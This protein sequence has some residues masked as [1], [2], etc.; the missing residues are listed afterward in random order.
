MN[1][2]S[3]IQRF[4]DWLKKDVELSVL[5]PHKG[6]VKE[7]DMKPIRIVGVV[8]A[9][10]DQKHRT[11]QKLGPGSLGVTINPRFVSV[12]CPRVEKHTIQRLIREENGEYLLTIQGID[13]D[14]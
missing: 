5:D 10:D 7:K 14:E 8:F 3:L 1:K 2:P 4:R 12:L 13:L 9:E 6:I 11:I